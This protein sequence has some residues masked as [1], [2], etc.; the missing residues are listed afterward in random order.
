MLYTLPNAWSITSVNNK[1]RY[2]QAAAILLQELRSLEGTLEYF[3]DMLCRLRLTAASHAL[4]IGE[5]KVTKGQSIA[6]RAIAAEQQ[7][8]A[9]CV[10]N[11][12]PIAK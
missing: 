3:L 8:Q 2:R 7:V 11:G 4:R 9:V 6:R 10:V 1:G 5:K 12:I